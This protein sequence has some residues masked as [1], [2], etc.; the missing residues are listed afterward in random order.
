MKNL[1]SV[2][3]ESRKEDILKILHCYVM[4][5]KFYMK[6]VITSLNKL[7]DVIWFALISVPNHELKVGQIKSGNF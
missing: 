5:R 6:I 4:S 1:R 2:R 7:T 3:D